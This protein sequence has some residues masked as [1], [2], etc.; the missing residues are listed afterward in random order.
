[1][2]S[3]IDKLQQ[4]S[5]VFFLGAKNHTELPLYI[6]NWNVAMLPFLNNKQIQMCNP[7]KL[8]EYIA[9]GTPVVTT[10]FNAV[11]DYRKFVQIVDQRTSLYKAI[12][13]ASAEITPSVN[14][15]NLH[16]ISDLS[17]ITKVKN[18]RQT[19]VVKESWERRAMDIQRYLFMC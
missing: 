18:F 14:F 3:K 17:T 5:N 10:D 4:F 15:E 12:L 16:L 8:R 9:S 7:L 13:L 6:K 1:V 19:L 2:N 11:Q